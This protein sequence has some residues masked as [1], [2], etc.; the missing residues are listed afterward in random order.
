L[1]EYLEPY[2]A[3]ARE[4]GPTFE[5]TLWLSREKQRRRFEVIAGMV[6]LE[7]RIVVDAGCGL[8]DF[9][10]YLVEIGVRIRGY[11]GLE[12]VESV[13]TEARRRGLPGARFVLGDFVADP[14]VFSAALAEGRGPGIM[15]FSGSLNT[16]T[17]ER[18][19]E[20][21]AYAWKAVGE[22]GEV[23]SGGSGGVVFNFLSAS[24]HLP[25]N[26][27]LGP[28]KRF[29]PVAMLEWALERTPL[30]R[31]RQD[32]MGGQDATIAL[33]KVDSGAGDALE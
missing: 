22:G 23:G 8:G 16:L 18:A 19:L 7:D 1:G 15:V 3:A 29:D 2:K 24:D 20:V 17:Q 10:A 5:A 9:A 21:L 27:E 11:V 12:G 32:Y 26:P 6:G 31:F 28:A 13:V 14:S 33:W 30:V 4:F 25:P